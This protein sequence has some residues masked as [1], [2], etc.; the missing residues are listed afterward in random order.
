MED[1]DL[2]IIEIRENAYDNEL[3]DIYKREILDRDKE[4]D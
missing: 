3:A 4:Y 2:I 1:L